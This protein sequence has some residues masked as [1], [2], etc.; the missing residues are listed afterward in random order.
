MRAISERARTM[1]LS[2]KNAPCSVMF[3][4]RLRVS[5]SLQTPQW[6]SSGCMA[7]IDS[8]VNITSPYSD[9][10][11]VIC[12]RHHFNRALLNLTNRGTQTR[13][14]RAYSLFMCTFRRTMIASIVLLMGAATIDNTCVELFSLV[15]NSNISII[16]GNHNP[17]AIRHRSSAN[18]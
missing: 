10:L 9:T 4:S 1:M 17:W 15:Y 12:F 16:C 13:G 5:F 14:I 11:Q 18:C 7:N 8:S 2:P 6:L 3:C